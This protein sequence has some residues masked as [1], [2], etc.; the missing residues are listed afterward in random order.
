MLGSKLEIETVRALLEAKLD[1]QSAVVRIAAAE[2]VG[3]LELKSLAE[4]VATRLR[5]AGNS[6]EVLAY[7]EALGRLKHP[8][9]IDELVAV[10]TDTSAGAVAAAARALV[11]LEH[12]DVPLKVRP[13]LSKYLSWSLPGA[14]KA[15]AESFAA[16]GS[17]LIKY[18][19][20][21]SVPAL[22]RVVSRGRSSLV[23]MPLLLDLLGAT[24]RE[25]L[26]SDPF[27]RALVPAL[28]DVLGH[29]DEE[30]RS[31]AIELLCRI[32][33]E[34]ETLEAALRLGL[35]DEEGHVRMLTAYWVAQLGYKSLADEL[36]GLLRMSSTDEERAGYCYALMRLKV[37]CK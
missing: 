19:D 22:S 21:Q 31:Y 11:E 34:Q 27:I 7:C 16:V 32:Q 26:V 6:P 13:L 24:S 5:R 28:T 14:T 15:E 12:P 4:K 33:P 3:K 36:V 18:R 35:R 23:V 25:R 20:K 30:V 37:S 1:D 10:L 17:V 29:R 9:A 8:G 2:A